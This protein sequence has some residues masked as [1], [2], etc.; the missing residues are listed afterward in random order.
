MNRI[1]WL[2]TVRNS[3]M[4]PSDRCLE[5]LSR[6]GIERLQTY[7]S[8]CQYIK[9]TCSVFFYYIFLIDF[10]LKLGSDPFFIPCSGLQAQRTP[11][12]RRRRTSRLACSVNGHDSG[13]DSLEVPTICKAYVFGLCKSISL[14]NMALYGTVPPLDRILKFLLI[15]GQAENA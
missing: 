15:L 2:N 13:T 1:R 6:I 12:Q 8:V 5:H 7:P 9:N 14:Q 4:R 10:P 3:K 11:R